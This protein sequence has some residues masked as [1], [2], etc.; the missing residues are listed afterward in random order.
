MALELVHGKPHQSGF[1][2]LDLGQ[3][4]WKQLVELGIKH[5]WRPE[6]APH[7]LPKDGH[8]CNF[9]SWYFWDQ[10]AEV[11]KT[12]ANAWAEALERAIQTPE[13]K[14]A[15][16]PDF[17]RRNPK[18]TE[19]ALED[20]NYARFNGLSREMVERFVQFLHR[21]KFIYAVWD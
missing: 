21:G 7:D 3:T 1:E 10:P 6:V 9:S 19:A 20:P 18:G 14:D 8:L 4:A 11:T 12:Q 5:G 13:L 16:L 17:L 15:S 2:V